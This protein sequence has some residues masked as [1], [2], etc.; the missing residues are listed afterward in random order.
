MQ[1]PDFSKLAWDMLR[2]MAV[3]DCTVDA[4][5]CKVLRMSNGQFSANVCAVHGALIQNHF[6]E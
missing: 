1:L 3:Y 2:L 4:D 5:E 6:R